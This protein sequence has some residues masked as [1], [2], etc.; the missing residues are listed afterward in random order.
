M[1]AN[2]PTRV[3]L[4]VALALSLAACAGAT[5]AT[6]SDENVTEDELRAQPTPQQVKELFS[7]IDDNCAGNSNG[8]LT[9]FN[10][11]RF[12]AADAAR[13]LRDEDRDASGVDCRDQRKV[14]TSRESA[15]KLF[16]AHVKDANFETKTCLKDTLSSA[17]RTRLD[18]F[19]SDPTNIAVFS[20]VYTDGDNSEACLYFN[21]HVYR[22]DGTLMELTFN[23]TD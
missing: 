9:T 19:V 20:S 12:K 10:V 18:K 17:Q 13:R 5:E 8:R 22:K 6:P 4:A 1:D 21:F 3:C 11:A 16:R 15:V 7:A 2:L 23:Y 14:S